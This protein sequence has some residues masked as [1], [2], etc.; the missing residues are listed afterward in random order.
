MVDPAYLVLTLLWWPMDTYG[1]LAALRIL[2][3][4]R[5]QGKYASATAKI[6]RSS[7]SALGSALAAEVLASLRAGNLALVGLLPAL[8]FLSYLGPDLLSQWTFRL[9]FLAL[10]ALGLLP[11]AFYLLRRLLAP[12]ELLRA[13]LSAGEA[14]EASATRLNG[15]L[16]PFLWLALPWLGLSWI[17]DAAS[18][19]FPDWIALGLA[20]PS[21]AATLMPLARSEDL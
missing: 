12:L 15:R 20:L 17:F 1:R 4:Q 6:W 16:R 7:T 3:T 5:T 10:V 11:S 13:P 19:A 14:L 9:G 2:L 18:L 8:A 21:L